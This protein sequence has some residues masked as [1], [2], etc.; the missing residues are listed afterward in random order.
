MSTA[1][2]LGKLTKVTTLRENLQTV[3]MSQILEPIE[4]IRTAS[5]V[6]QLQNMLKSDSEAFTE[7]KLE[8]VLNEITIVHETYVALLHASTETFFKLQAKF[9]AHIAS[10]LAIDRRKEAVPAE[11]QNEES[12]S[13]EDG[14]NAD[15]QSAPTPRIDEEEEDLMEDHIKVELSEDDQHIIVRFTVQSTIEA[16]NTKLVAV[17]EESKTIAK[18]ES[19]SKDHFQNEA[20]ALPENTTTDITEQENGEESDL[21]NISQDPAD[22]EMDNAPST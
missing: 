7:S 14:W 6:F 17:A 5:E 3:I 13:F 2:Y 18:S 4:K 21:D 20:P 16:S 10:L 19:P 15:F 22:S 1:S 9:N 11:P 8:N 12:T